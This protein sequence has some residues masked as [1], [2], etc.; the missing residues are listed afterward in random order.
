MVPSVST[1]R[2]S[3]PIGLLDT[4]I[5]QP[6]KVMVLTPIQISPPRIP[7]IPYQSLPANSSVIS[8][9]ATQMELKK[10][11]GGSSIEDAASFY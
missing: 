7:F 1:K 11:L 9:G 5:T 8:S 3:T 10:A 2:H 6:S 4:S